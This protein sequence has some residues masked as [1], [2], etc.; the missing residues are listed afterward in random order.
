ML[1]CWR[2]I[3]TEYSSYKIVIEK[4]VLNNANTVPVRNQNLLYN[5]Q[6]ESE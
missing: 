1:L 2:Q 4:T 6:T 3:E 5:K